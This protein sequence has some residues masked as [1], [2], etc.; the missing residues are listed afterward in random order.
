[1]SNATKEQKEKI[2]QL[3]QEA[4]KQDNDLRAQFKVGEKFRFIRDRLNALLSRVE[5]NLT[6]LQ[7][8]S[9]QKLTQ[10]QEDEALVYVYLFNA[11][12]LVLKTWQKMVAPSVF[13]EYS[14][15][16]PIYADKTAIESYIRSKSNKVQH[17]YLTVAVK[18]ENILALPESASSSKD[19]LGHPV[20]KVKEGSLH[21]DKLFS[22]THN[23]IEYMLS[24][25]ELI[26]KNGE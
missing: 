16:R 21:F 14:I 11:Q 15:N 10:L 13:Y 2:L 5:E 19:T 24:D 18:K 22:F 3:I 20:I 9:E 25:G 4:V 7:K 26:K 6:T 8:E 17:G 1:M 23:N 12:G